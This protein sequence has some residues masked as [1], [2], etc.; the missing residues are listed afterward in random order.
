MCNP[1]R[2]DVTATRQ[3]VESWE[4]EVR[5]QVTLT[6][7]AAGEVRVREELDAGI[8][9]PTLDALVDVLAADDEW[10][11]VDGAYRHGME[12][13]FVAYH[14]DEQELEIVVRLTDDVSADAEAAITAH[15]RFDETMTVTGTGR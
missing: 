5:R 2:I 1:R 10:E 12:D 4:H 6:G 9:Q 13:G 7:T 11:L 15:G 14:V 8:G 3:L